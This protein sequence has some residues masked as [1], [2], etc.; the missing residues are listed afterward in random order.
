MKR[1]KFKMRQPVQ[2]K[3]KIHN[4]AAESKTICGHVQA[5]FD[6]VEVRTRNSATDAPPRFVCTKPRLPPIRFPDPCARTPRHVE[7]SC[8]GPNAPNERSQLHIMRTHAI[9]PWGNFGS[10]S[11]R[12]QLSGWRRH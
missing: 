12:A 10:R 4:R 2:K 8:D 9:Q 11:S 1:T 7:A 6:H 3:A 5:S